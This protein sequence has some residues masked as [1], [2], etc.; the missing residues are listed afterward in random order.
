[1]SP[2][3]L[4]DLSRLEAALGGDRGL[5][6]EILQMYESTAS[7]DVEELRLAVDVGDVDGIVRRAHAI[8]GASGNV[9]ADR[10]MDV[11]GLIERAGREGSLERA[12]A[13]VPD[14]QAVFQQTVQACRAYRAA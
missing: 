5:M 3:T 8:K 7:M 12:V 6:A 13:L 11:A 9:G 4:L 2:S 1:M 10:V 14:L